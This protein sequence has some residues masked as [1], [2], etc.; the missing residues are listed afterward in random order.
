M[1]GEESAAG[2]PAPVEITSVVLGVDACR[3]G[4]VGALLEPGAP[5]PRVVVA[6]SLEALLDAAS[7]HLHLE[8]VAVDIPIGLPDTAVREADRLARAALPGRASSVFSTPV[9]AAVAAPTYEEANAA[10]RAATT[11]GISQQ[12]WAIVPKIREAEAFVRAHPDLRVVEVHPEV[13]FA[14]LAGAPIAARKKDSD[15]PAARLA[16][17]AAAGVASPS[18]LKGSGYGSDD[19]LDACAA[20]WTAARV[21]SGLARQL[22]EPPQVHSDGLP[23]AIWV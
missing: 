15:G 12:A 4:W 1:P 18:I 17:L 22:P 8:V 23:A 3:A 13:S 11:K 14:E 21:A 7:E 5:R 20:A 9:R 6:G 10:N 2:R 16:A 19:V